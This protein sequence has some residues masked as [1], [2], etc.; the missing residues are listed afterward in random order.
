M[1]PPAWIYVVA[2]PNGAGKSTLARM[3][4][5]DVPVVNPDDLARTINPAAPEAAAFA[6][7]RQALAQVQEHLDAGR[8]FGVETTLAGRW[9]FR[10]M[11]Q[12]SGEGAA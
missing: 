1:N 6:A 9:I 7:G 4:L 2:G 8:S 5:P 12:A 3:L 10:V 11:K